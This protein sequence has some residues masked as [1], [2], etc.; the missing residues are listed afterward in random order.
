MLKDVLEIIP[1]YLQDYVL[2]GQATL[3]VEAC[4]FIRGEL[5]M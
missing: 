1:V 4:P 3:L 2:S 5:G